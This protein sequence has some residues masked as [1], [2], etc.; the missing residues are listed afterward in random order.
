MPP[1]CPPPGRPS[2]PQESA[3]QPGADPLSWD[4]RAEPTGDGGLGRCG[5]A[6]LRDVATPVLVGRTPWLGAQVHHSF[7][8]GQ[9]GKYFQPLVCVQGPLVRFPGATQ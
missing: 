2:G 4:S 8:R 7:N 1:P 3:D 5:T 9:L 6:A